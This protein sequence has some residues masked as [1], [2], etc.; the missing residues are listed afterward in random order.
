[1]KCI[2]QAEILKSLNAL[3]GEWARQFDVVPILSASFTK[4]E[5]GRVC[6]NGDPICPLLEVDINDTFVDVELIGFSTLAGDEYSLHIDWP[7]EGVPRIK[8]ISHYTIRDLK[9]PAVC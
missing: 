3:V 4:D 1:M 8:Q 7:F 9:Q 2:H 6:I 5:A